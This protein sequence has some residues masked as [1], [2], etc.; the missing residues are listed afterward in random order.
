MIS[1]NLGKAQ[2]CV[3]VV[4]YRTL[5]EPTGLYLIEKSAIHEQDGTTTSSVNIYRILATLACRIEELDIEI[6]AASYIDSDGQLIVV[7]VDDDYIPV[8]MRVVD[9]AGYLEICNLTGENAK[10]FVEFLKSIQDDIA[11]NFLEL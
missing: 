4:R 3:E 9:Y 10:V 8:G 11:Y 2:K 6:I 1:I 5:G 7:P